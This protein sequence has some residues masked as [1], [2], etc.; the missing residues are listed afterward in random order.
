[1]PIDISTIL[2][3]A[4]PASAVGLLSGATW[5][6]RRHLHI[7]E[8]DEILIFSGRTH[9]TEDGRDVGF[10]V[11][12]G[13]RAFSIPIIEKVDK[14]DMSLITVPMGIRGAYS[15]G[16]I[17]LNLHAI[18]NV[19]VSDD[20]RLMGNAIERF[21]GHSRG[22]IARVA[23]ETLEGHLR[24][25]IATMTPEE[26][27][28][29]RLKFAERLLDEAGEDLRRLGLQLDTLKIQHVS[30]ER[31]YL[32][33]IGRKRIAEIVRA[34]EVAESDAA[35]AATE[36]EAAAKARGGVAKTR[37]KAN[38]QKK[39]N[40]VREIK[41]ALDAEAKSEEERT[42]AAA[43]RAR[44]E[45]EMELQRIRAELEQLRLTAD[46]TL[47]A[48]VDRKVKQLIAAGEAAAIEAKGA[49]IAA[50]Y[51]HVAQ[52]FAELGPDAMDLVVVQHLDD[53]VDQVTQAATSLHADQVS[54][55]DSGDGASVAAYA[56]AYPAT[57]DALLSQVSST[58][59]VDIAGVLN[60]ARRSSVTEPTP[61]L[62]A[63]EAPTLDAA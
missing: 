59:G 56:A 33:S 13:G 60:G 30:D 34:A 25:V 28:E 42:A 44:A 43:K 14:M 53:I 49:A 36:A 5:F 63:P 32:D 55:L 46:V 45:A 20:P 16:G 39:A 50:A 52:A 8:P 48:E 23:K 3:L 1:M 21:L 10:R 31:N 57:V 2:A 6:V 51:G 47:P 4:A 11:V 22:E 40:E 37:A 19:K 38:V 41:A 58:L 15:E 27:N 7:C 17:P 18:A 26:V 9:A 29:D 35:R 12:Q 54:L 62:P 24:G 61:E